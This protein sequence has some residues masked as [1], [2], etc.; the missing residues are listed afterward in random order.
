MVYVSASILASNF[1]DLGKDCEDALQSGADFIHFD[2]MDGHFVPNISFGPP[3]LASLSKRIDAVYDVHLMISDP[4]F[5]IDSFANAGADM[6]T[7]H[8]EAESDT[9]KT[10]EAIK[11]CGL[12]VGLTLRPETPVSELF[13]YLADIDMILVMTVEPGFGGQ[14]F[15][16]EMCDKIALLKEELRRSG[17]EDFLIEVDGGIDDCTAKMAV[18][19]GAN[20][21]VAG[22]YIFKA[23]NRRDAIERL[24]Q[25][26]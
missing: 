19:A 13:P 20:V 5:Y 12:K 26:K 15:M 25:K 7:F 18:N 6:I 9:K 10:I 22:S 2:V 21:L 3:V 24:K 4:L 1:Y 14:L 17:R 23:K 11:D 8:I 16:P